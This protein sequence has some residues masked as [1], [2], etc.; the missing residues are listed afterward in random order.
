M[1]DVPV[2]SADCAMTD[3]CMLTPGYCVAG[4]YPHTSPLWTYSAPVA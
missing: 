3:D 2:I 1:T 4:M